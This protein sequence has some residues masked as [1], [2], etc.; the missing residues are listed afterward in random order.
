MVGG[1]DI[2]HPATGPGGPGGE[3]Y[4]YTSQFKVDHPQYLLGNRTDDTP[5]DTYHYWERNALNYAL[6]GVRRY[7]TGMAGE[8]VNNYDLDAL[9]L[10][11]IRFT[12]YF[13]QAEAYAQRHVLTQTVRKIRKLCD[14]VAARRGR[15]VRLSAR[16]PDTIELGLRSGIDTA[17]W[18]EQGLLDI[19]A[20]GGGY[21]PFGTPWQEIVDVANRAGVPALACLNHGI[22]AKDVRRIHAAAHR[23]HSAGVN[24]FKLWNFWYC[25]DYYHP[26]D[27]NPLTLDFVRDLTQPQQLADK[28]LSYQVDRVQDPTHFVGSTHFHHG[29]AGQTPMTIGTADDGIGQ[30][31]TIDIPASVVAARA[32]DHKALIV[33]DLDNFW[34][35]EDRLELYWNCELIERVDYALQANEGAEPYRA[36][37]PLRCAQLKAG[38]NH[39][40]LRLVKNHPDVDPFI[41]LNR[42][43]LMLGDSAG[44][45]PSNI[46]SYA[47]RLY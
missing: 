38:E 4:Y 45:L 26:K 14:E 16:V 32:A 47:D 18:L 44:N 15:P 1:T 21:C 12:F 2:E 22:F 10:D 6:G 35:P 39:L 19:V 29:W 7:F 31:I 34:A 5:P 30:V 9:E 23:A 20:I 25:F 8:L 11:F 24:G 36:T 17:A 3:P 42:V 13:R 43:E 27:A 37:V 46:A 28:V 33:L 41:V 40:E